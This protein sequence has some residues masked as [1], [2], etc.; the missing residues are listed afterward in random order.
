MVESAGGVGENVLD[1]TKGSE[2]YTPNRCRKQLAATPD[3][4]SHVAENVFELMQAVPKR[5]RSAVQIRRSRVPSGGH[6]NS[7]ASERAVLLTTPASTIGNLEAKRRWLPWIVSPALAA[8]V[9]LGATRMDE[10]AVSALE[11]AI[12]CL[13]FFCLRG[14]LLNVFR[15]LPWNFARKSKRLLLTAPL[16][17]LRLALVVQAAAI[18]LVFFA[19]SHLRVTPQLSAAAL[20]LMAM[21]GGALLHTSFGF[22]LTF[23]DVPKT[24]RSRRRLIGGV[25]L[26]LIGCAAWGYLT[27]KLTHFYVVHSTRFDSVDIQ[28][29]LLL[30][31]TLCLAQWVS[32]IPLRFAKSDAHTTEKLKTHRDRASKRR[33]PCDFNVKTPG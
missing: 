33:C 17:Y 13:L 31:A 26:S 5:I 10:P 14:F 2:V 4:A 28:V 25:M 24:G 6:R 32:T 22:I 3:A 7:S 8:A 23:L 20:L 27:S 12:V 19:A 11:V 21:A 1:R 9:G 18:I 15:L 16:G 29:G 30:F